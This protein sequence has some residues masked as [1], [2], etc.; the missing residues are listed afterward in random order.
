MSEV[1]IFQDDFISS[2]V[3]QTLKNLP[4]M[5]Q[6]Q[7]LQVRSLD[8]QDPLEKGMAAHSSI[9]PGEFHGKRS[10]VVNNQTQQSS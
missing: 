3:V 4:P 2:L 7:E 9:L 1:Y 8:W 5:Q 6:P 10:L